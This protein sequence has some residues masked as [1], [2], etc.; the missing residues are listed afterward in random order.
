MQY[1]LI[2]EEG[3]LVAYGTYSELTL[4]AK[5]EHLVMYFIIPMAI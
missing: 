2:N 1:E 4:M 3:N 5:I